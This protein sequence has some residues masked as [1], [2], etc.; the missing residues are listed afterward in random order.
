MSYIG[1]DGKEIVERVI[2]SPSEVK[3]HIE[4]LKRVAITGRCVPRSAL[5]SPMVFLPP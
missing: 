2:S 4:G 1:H 3:R 5:T